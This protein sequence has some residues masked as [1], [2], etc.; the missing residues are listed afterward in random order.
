MV[1]EFVYISEGEGESQREGGERA[2]ERVNMSLNY[3]F[4]KIF[5]KP[6]LFQNIVL[7]PYL[8]LFM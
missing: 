2:G 7:L 6:V 8:H 5:E 1:C 4:G 3:D